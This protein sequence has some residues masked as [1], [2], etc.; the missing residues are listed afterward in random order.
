MRSEQS[1]L[2]YNTK[3]MITNTTQFKNV[4]DVLDYFKEEETCRIFLAQQRWGDKP[5]CPHC[6]STK[7]YVTNRG[8]K[9]AEKTCYKKFS[10]ITGTVM[11]NT[12]IKLR[13]W[14]AAMYFI[15]SRKR[16]VS[17]YELADQLHISQKT[18]WFLNHRIREMF[19]MRAP[20]KI[21]IDG[22]V[23]SDESFFGGKN[24]NRH[25]DKK[26]KN[27]QGRSFKDKT[28][29]MGI[30]DDKGKMRT[31]QVPNT[32]AK[33]LLPIL[34]KNLAIGATLMTDEWTGYNGASELFNHKIV[35]HGAKQYVSDGVHCNGVENYW[36]IAKRT[37]ATYYHFT[38][39]HIER[40]MDETTYRFNT[41]L[42]SNEERFA[43]LTTRVDGRLK[44]RDLIGR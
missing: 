25:H 14:F 43:A 20:E 30:L 22:V 28:P 15:S 11:E 38:P 42:L 13:Y 31:F 2:C 8:Y 6:G 39:K 12:K 41:R 24:R 17:S 35:N 4:I 1:S 27:S 5:C 44:Y 21:L 29:I 18:A 26:V 36:S 32:E 9:C 37:L 40:Y 10:V 23:Q 16:G 7:A 19:K 3:M 34:E 33:T